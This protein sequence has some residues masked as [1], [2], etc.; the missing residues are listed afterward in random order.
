MMDYPCD[1]FG[2]CSFI[3]F[4]S[5]MQTN[6]YIDHIDAH[7]ETQMNAILTRVQICLTCESKARFPLPELTARVDG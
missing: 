6:R 3:R 5:T 7:G 1:K 4:G 2:D